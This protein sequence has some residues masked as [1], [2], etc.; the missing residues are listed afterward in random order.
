MGR[1]TP[2]GK[3]FRAV[4]NSLGLEY[5]SLSFTYEGGRLNYDDLIWHHG[6]E[7]G[8]EI[9]FQ[10]KQLGGKPVIYFL[11]PGGV[12]ISANVS[13]SLVPAW[14]FS[15]LYPPTPIKKVFS[16]GGNREHVEWDVTVKPG[17]EMVDKA[18]GT[19]VAYLFWE[20]Q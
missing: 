2:L 10:N 4:E 1:N 19:E 14:S 13:L 18:T 9:Y 11:P 12:T 6:M 8:D 15:A 7:D 16:N 17:G 20:A 3:L 5:G